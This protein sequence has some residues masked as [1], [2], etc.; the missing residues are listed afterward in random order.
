MKSN[1][2]VK[3]SGDFRTMSSIYLHLNM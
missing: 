2:T 1:N 3:V